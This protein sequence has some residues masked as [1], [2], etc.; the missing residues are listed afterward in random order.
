MVRDEVR[1]PS[2]NLVPQEPL[3]RKVPGTMFDGSSRCPGS[4]F[5]FPEP[6]PNVGDSSTMFRIDHLHIEKSFLQ[7]LITKDPSGKATGDAI[8]YANLRREFI[9]IAEYDE[10]ELE[11]VIQQQIDDHI[12]GRCP[13]PSCA[14]A[15]HRSHPT[16]SQK[17]LYEIP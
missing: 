17:S 7:F 11:K 5:T 6:G 12:S 4:N 13:T 9:A 1:E 8:E 10:N 16:R 14:T 15:F 3:L 2:T